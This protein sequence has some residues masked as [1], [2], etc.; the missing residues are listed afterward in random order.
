MVDTIETVTGCFSKT[1][2]RCFTY[3]HGAKTDSFSQ[4]FP[5]HIEIRPKN[6][7]GNFKAVILAGTDVIKRS[8]S[9]VDQIGRTAH[10]LA[11]HAACDFADFV[12][13]SNFVVMNNPRRECKKRHEFSTQYLVV[14]RNRTAD[15]QLQ[16][17]GP[18]MLCFLSNESVANHRGA[19]FA[20]TKANPVFFIVRIMDNIR[21]RL[22]CN[23]KSRKLLGSLPVVQ[24]FFCSLGNVTQ[25]ASLSVVISVCHR[26]PQRILPLLFGIDCITEQ[27]PDIFVSRFSDC[28]FS[29]KF[30]II[31]ARDA[32]FNIV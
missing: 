12:A 31:N 22:F 30:R 29:T 21:K 13:I 32:I 24:S 5:S 28:H 2:G 4:T 15:I 23:Q 16:K 1:E 17:T 10:K 11:F 8:G 18:D 26:I 25:F 3:V 6:L 27:H 7:T 19:N 9:N 14:R 20:F